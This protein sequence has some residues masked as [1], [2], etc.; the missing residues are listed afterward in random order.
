MASC[1]SFP[2]VI[3]PQHKNVKQ[4]LTK[5]CIS[6]PKVINPQQYVPHSFGTTGC[7]SF[8]KVINPQLLDKNVP[9]LYVVSRSLK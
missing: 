2:K 3:N 4:P 5:C 9:E 8:P 7:I 6:F 1:I